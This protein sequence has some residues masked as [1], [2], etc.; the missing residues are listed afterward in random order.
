MVEKGL[1]GRQGP[2]G[3]PC[4]CSLQRLHGPDGLKPLFA[5]PTTAGTGSETTGVAIFDLEEIHA[6]TGIAHR[7]LKPT[8]G[9]VDPQNTQTLP[10]IVAAS[11]GLEVLTHAIESYT[12]MPFNRRPRPERPVLRPA[13]Q[14]ANPISDIWA[15]EALR[16]LDCH[17][18]QAVE[19]PENEEARGMMMKK[20]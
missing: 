3:V 19:N 2:A 13:Y 18:I 10:P 17:F 1:L 6:K 5:I 7:R 9:I 11:T 14:G 8:L 4:R 16:I 12:V 15:I 20:A